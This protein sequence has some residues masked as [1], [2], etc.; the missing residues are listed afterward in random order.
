MSHFKSGYYDNSGGTL[1]DFS[2]YFPAYEPF[3]RFYETISVGGNNY[4]FTLTRNRENTTNYMPFA[5]IE[6]L[7][8][9]TSTAKKNS[10]KF[11]HYVFYNKK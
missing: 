2:E 4:T 6:S 8:T 3:I 1:V 9:N 5:T 7:T 10:K 11:A